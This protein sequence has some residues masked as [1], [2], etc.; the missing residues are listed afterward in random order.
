M[1]IYT[2]GNFRLLYIHVPKTGGTSI[3]EQ[4]FAERWTITYHDRLK[5]TKSTHYPEPSQ[6]LRYELLAKSKVFDFQ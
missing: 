3:T 1:P 2:Q 5:T 6:H 4:F